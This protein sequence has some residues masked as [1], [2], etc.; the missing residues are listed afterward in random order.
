[1]ASKTPADKRLKELAKQVGDGTLTG[2]VTFDQPYAAK[3]HNDLTYRHT[4]GQAGYLSSALWENFRSYYR[5]LARE[6]LHGNLAQ[7]MADCCDDLADAAADRAPR[8]TGVLHNSAAYQVHDGGQLAHERPPVAPREPAYVRNF[9]PGWQWN[10]N[11]PGSG[12]PGFRR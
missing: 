6:V 2:T 11:G 12:R 9:R 1:M 5:K 7:G 10:R 4:R 3:Q 8:D